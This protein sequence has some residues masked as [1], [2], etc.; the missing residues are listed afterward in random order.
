M[1]TALNEPDV[2]SIHLQD[3]GVIPN[4]RLPLLHYR[5]AVRVAGDPASLFEALFSGNEWSGIWRNGVY[6]YHHY[7]STAHE[8]LGVY[9]GSA[10]IQ[11]GGES[12]PTVEV[13]A[14][15]AVVIPAGVAH[16]KEEA[17]DDFAVVGAYP[18]GQSADLCRGN[19]KERL[20]ADKALAAVPR[21]SRDPLYGTGGPLLEIW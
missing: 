1:T 7:H 14:G 17:S 19:K 18:S 11:F 20:E 5:Q 2:R 9:A 13:S 6:P 12:G 16:R 10:R 21:P 8:V 3:D 4:S 15:D